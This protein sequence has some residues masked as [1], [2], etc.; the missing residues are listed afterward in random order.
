MYAWE[1]QGPAKSRTNGKIFWPSVE[2][3]KNGA[4]GVF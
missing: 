2:Y 1:P 3:V 4:V